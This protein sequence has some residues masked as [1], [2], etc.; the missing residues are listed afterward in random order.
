[1]RSSR[2]LSLLVAACLLAATIGPPPAGAQSASDLDTLVAPIALYPDALLADVL[3]AS[4]FPVQIVEAARAVESGPVDANVAA[5]WDPSV[6][7][8]VSYPS[9]LTMMNDRI[10][11]TTQ[12]GEAVAQDQ[13]AVL[14]AVQRVRGEAQ[15]AGN[16]RT[17]DKQTVTTSGTNIVVEPTD[18]QVLYVPQYD[19]V[20][21]L[22]PP[23]PW[24]YYAPAY[25]VLAFGDGFAVGALTA[26]GIGWGFGPA[27]CCGH[28]TVIN[29]HYRYG[30]PYYGGH[31]GGHAW[32][33]PPRGS[34]G[35]VGP[36]FHGGGRPGGFGPGTTAGMGRPGGGRPGAVGPGGG[37]G[38]GRPGGFDRPGRA[39]AGR[40]GGN[41]VPGHAP[42]GQML[43]SPRG[44]G[45]GFTRDA[46]PA[47][48]TA[49]A[50]QRGFAA[51]SPRAGGGFSAGVAPERGNAFDHVGG[52]GWNARSFSARGAQSFG[53]GFG[54]GGI[55]H[56]G[57]AMQ[58]GGFHGGGGF[59]GG[60]GGGFGGGHGGGGGGHR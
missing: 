47:R 17:N 26:Y 41:A 14:A 6:Q 35:H 11:W 29:N 24:G 7:A 59:G 44:G 58:G 31:G 42:Q 22:S 51:G 43:G 10:T 4:A 28:I 36:G 5:E 21:I 50:P 37:L 60:H 15:K 33:P 55:A 3:P 48:A 49:G 57:G 53:G 19:P 40:P 39:D 45:H 52:G 18:P 56:T 8:L 32:R 54:G 46:G 13:S 9:V 1:M 34:V 2:P 23:P 25:G 16:L 38:A 20:A 30:H 12:L 27:F